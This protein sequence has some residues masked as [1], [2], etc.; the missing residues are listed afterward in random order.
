MQIYSQVKNINKN[1][2]LIWFQFVTSFITQIFQLSQG[3]KLEVKEKCSFQLF[4]SFKYLT[5]NPMPIN[6]QTKSIIFLQQTHFK[7]RHKKKITKNINKTKIKKDFFL[8]INT[9]V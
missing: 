7:S 4:L 2:S 5:N 9:H 8:Y 3:N 1:I 6:R